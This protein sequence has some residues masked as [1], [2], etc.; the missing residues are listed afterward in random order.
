MQKY[1]II[2]I[3]ILCFYSCKQS[4]NAKKVEVIK[5]V[6]QV[7]IPKQEVK[8]IGIPKEIDTLYYSKAAILNF[9]DD[10][11]VRLNKLDSTF[12][13]DMRYATSNNFLKQ[14]VYD[15]EDCLVR[16][17]TAKQLIIVNNEF[18]KLG[19]SI[20]F[21]DCY[22]PLDIQKRMWEI[23]PDKRYVANPAIGSNHN[24]GAAVDITLI[25]SLQ[26]KLNMGTDFDFFGKK[27]HHA[28]LELPEGVLENR[29]M[30]KEIMEK[31][32]FMS[33]TSEWW[34]YNLKVSKKYDVS[35]FKVKCND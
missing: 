35:N 21:F 34:H 13:Y 19:Y 8:E 20:Q 23:F 25:D 16:Y 28:F 10:D 30:L 32:E 18:K 15:C 31:N 1:L 11:F 14:K 7:I 33:I 12:S 3:T 6:P 26:N 27:A 24:R 29:R 9:K 2:I 22:R 5:E 17:S 4:T